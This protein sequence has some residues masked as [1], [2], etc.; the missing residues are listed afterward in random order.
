MGLG[1]INLYEEIIQKHID[2]L[3][4]K[5][6]LSKIETESDRLSAV[7]WLNDTA[8]DI[9]DIDKLSINI[10]IKTSG[11]YMLFKFNDYTNSVC[12]GALS[13]TKNID[14]MLLDI[15]KII[16]DGQHVIK[17]INTKLEGIQAEN[18]LMLKFRYKFG[19][20]KQCKIAYWDYTNIVIALNDKAIDLMLDNL[21]EQNCAGKIEKVLDEVWHNNVAEFIR[22]FNDMHINKY[23]GAELE[24]DSIEDALKDNMLSFDDIRDIVNKNKDKSGTQ[25]LKSVKI[26]SGLG[27]FAAIVLWVIDYDNKRI[28][29]DILDDKVIDIENNRF[30]SDHSLFSRIEQKVIEESNNLAEVFNR[31]AS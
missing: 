19:Y 29:I 6:I 30:I 5:S 25:R 18:G 27:S 8:K 20:N 7:E 2:G 15:V 10:V 11:K 21:T 3:A 14:V 28:S 17:E 23:I 12:K 31:E 22:G 1:G 16:S 24:Y 26:I 9:T 13:I 4:D